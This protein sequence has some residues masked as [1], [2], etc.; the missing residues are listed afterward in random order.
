MSLI[1]RI[2][3]QTELENQLLLKNSQIGQASR[4]SITE[5]PTPMS[6]VD[7]ELIKDY[8]SQ[9]PTGFRCDQPSRI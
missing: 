5:L 1:Q 4:I 2:A 7:E 3:N 6:Q 9:F 8:Q